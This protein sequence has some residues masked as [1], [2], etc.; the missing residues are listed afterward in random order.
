MKKTGIRRLLELAGNA[1]PF[2]L[3]SAILSVLCALA[4]IAPYICVYFVIRDTG[5][6]EWTKMSIYGWAAAG[7]VAAQFLFYFSALMCSHIAAFRTTRNIKSLL[8]KHLATLPI[9]FHA[10]NP[11]GK[12]KKIV[13]NNV[14]QTEGCIAPL[15]DLV[16][17]A[18]TPIATIILLLSID[19][20]LGLICL[21]P[22]VI[23][24]TIQFSMKPDKKNK[25]YLEE[26]QNSLEDMNNAAVEYVRGISVVKVFGQTIFSF[27]NFLASIKR[28]EK[29][30]VKYILAFEVSISSFVTAINSG[31]FLLVPA[32]IL[33][34]R[35]A[36]DYGRFVLGFV[37]YILF[38][39][40]MAGMLM[41][42]RSVVSNQMKI[43]DSI[44]R[45]D[46]I[47]EEKPLP[48]PQ[49]MVKPRN[50]RIAFSHVS[51][52]YKDNTTPAVSDIS[53]TASPGTVT[54]LAGPSGSGKTTIASLM[55]RF[56]DVNSGS[57]SI[58]GVDI[59]NIPTG[60]L[61]EKVSFVFQDVHL[62]KISILDNIRFG[63]QDATREKAL[64][65]A[66]T[67]Q[68][69][70]IIDKLPH[71]IDTIIGTRGIFLSGGEQQRIALAR[72][73]LKESPVIILDEATA[74]ADPENEIKIQTALNELIKNKTTL[75]IAHRLS[76]IRNADQILVLD[77][78]KI[79]E[80]GNH[81]DLIALKGIY[82]NMWD[83]YQSGVK[84]KIAKESAHVS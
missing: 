55:L 76:T 41:N 12:L 71:G 52:S 35:Y 40:V 20:R 36:S 56:W 48:E 65:A 33:L 21:A 2:I 84:W 1:K 16:A 51:F 58:G 7:V 37:F 30:M 62:F 25:N 45:I 31:F 3:L 64:R 27:K 24:L 39:P 75:V 69:M 6:M 50:N 49:N 59:R 38:V 13:E 63:C 72:A 82:H 22:L 8:L 73:I 83:D 80:Q 44:Q 19:W 53:F 46:E 78:G 9:G 43:D 77:Q 26:Y 17:S 68:C 10:A 67:A 14:R 11:S 28:Y 32:G 57:I 15:P 23:A 70:D 60:S 74:F 79:V 5:T 54:A 34:S 4:S 66:A 81:H 29:Y 42:V 18:V 47:F 61:M